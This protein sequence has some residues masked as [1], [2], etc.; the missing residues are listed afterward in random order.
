M[1]TLWRHFYAP[2]LLWNA[3]HGLMPDGNMTA[4]SVC[5]E[6]EVGWKRAGASRLGPRGGAER[7]ESDAFRKAAVRLSRGYAA[8]GGSPKV[9]GMAGSGARNISAVSLGRS[10]WR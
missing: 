6:R 2:R 9:S 7:R 1:E 3:R 4:V 10:R 8:G 5:C